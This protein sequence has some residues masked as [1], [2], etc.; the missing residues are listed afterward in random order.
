MDKNT[1]TLEDIDNIDSL[2]AGINFYNLNKESSTIF[3]DKNGYDMNDFLL[4]QKMGKK[5]M[6]AP[7]ALIKKQRSK[8]KCK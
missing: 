4:G 2:I 3:F 6:E 5:I 1:K 7:S 8:S